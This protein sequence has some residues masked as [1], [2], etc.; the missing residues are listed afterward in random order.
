MHLQNMFHSAKENVLYNISADYIKLL[1]SDMLKEVEE[2][3]IKIRNL[4]VFNYY[5]S[6]FTILFYI[7][8]FNL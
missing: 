8:F 6:R 4:E 1:N 2:F 3:R 7:Y 5:R